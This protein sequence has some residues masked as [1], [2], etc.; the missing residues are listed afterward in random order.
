MNVKRIFYRGVLIILSVIIIVSCKGNV[1]TEP[2]V[3]PNNNQTTAPTFSMV[4]EQVFN[5]SCALVGCHAGSAPV[6]R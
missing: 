2:E 5:K 3:P 4:Q 6:F 1:S